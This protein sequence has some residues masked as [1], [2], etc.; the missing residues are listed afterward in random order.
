M[1][2]KEIVL[3]LGGI[4][5]KSRRWDGDKK[6]ETK[7]IIEEIIALGIENKFPLHEAAE[8]GLLTSVRKEF[9]CKEVLE[10]KRKGKRAKEIAVETGH[11]HQLP[12]GLT[13]KIIGIER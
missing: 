2:T 6:K 1:T 13:R 9:L 11:A 5:E 8:K 10:L 12:P 4:E 3:T 7:A